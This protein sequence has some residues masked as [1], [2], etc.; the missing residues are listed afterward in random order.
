[1]T[2]FL[3]NALSLGPPHGELHFRCARGEMCWAPDAAQLWGGGGATLDSVHG[4][5]CPSLR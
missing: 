5:D 3:I 4:A 1:M 2:E